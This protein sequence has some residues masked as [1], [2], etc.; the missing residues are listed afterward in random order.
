MKRKNAGFV[1]LFLL[2]LC[3]LTACRAGAPA[4]LVEGETYLEGTWS[5]D[6]LRVAYGFRPDGEGTLYVAGEIL[7]VRYGVKGDTLYLQT[8]GQ[9]DAHT[10]ETDGEDLLLD[11]VRF[12]PV[13]EDPDAE[14]EVSAALAQMRSDAEAE[15]SAKRTRN[16]LF[17]VTLLAAAGTV[18]ILVRYFRGKKQTKNRR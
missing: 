15:R 4:P 14:A 7:P 17:L 18:A 9:T 16:V 12:R 11:G 6:E 3:L 2:F 10:F 8:G 5:N 13:G 1:P